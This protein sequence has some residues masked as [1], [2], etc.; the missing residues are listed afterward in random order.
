MNLKISRPKL[1]RWLRWNSTIRKRMKRTFMKSQF[2]MLRLKIF[3]IQNRKRV[4][5]LTRNPNSRRMMKVNLFL[6]ST[7]D[8]S[9]MNLEMEAAQNLKIFLKKI[10]KTRVLPTRIKSL[11]SRS[12]LLNVIRPSNSFNKRS[13]S[14]AP[15]KR[16]PWKR[17]ILSEKLLNS[18]K[19]YKL[20][21]INSDMQMIN[22]RSSM[23]EPWKS[24]RKG[25]KTRKDTKFSLISSRLRSTISQSSLSLLRIS[26]RLV[27][28]PT[29]R[30]TWKPCWCNSWIELCKV[31]KPK[32]L[33]SC[34]RSCAH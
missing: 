16:E 26:L 32:I 28:A 33:R 21:M 34:W 15:H 6:L 8:L 1:P 19:E 31:V 30:S 13:M 2:L 22:S 7:Q 9:L 17:L 23:T 24:S 20:R 12:K 3:R 27:R 5:M 4:M 18:P 11:N 29:K 14:T 25:I 10:P